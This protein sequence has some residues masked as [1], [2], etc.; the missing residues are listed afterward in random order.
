[1]LFLLPLCAQ[2]P[3]GGRPAPKNL[4]ILKPDEV[5]TAMRSFNTSLGV[6]CDFC[7]V[8]GDNASDDKKPK[9]KARMM[10]EMTSQINTTHF[11]G[12]ER[13]SCYTCHHGENEPKSAPPPPA[14]AGQ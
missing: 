3:Q 7:H 5:M 2:P 14:P 9:L 1:M 10:I 13:V 6:K 4:K 11:N 12:K 8:A